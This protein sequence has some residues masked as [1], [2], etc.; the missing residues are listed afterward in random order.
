MNDLRQ[1]NDGL[2]NI[3]GS[4]ETV[5]AA[6]RTQARHLTAETASSMDFGRVKSGFAI[7]LHMH[8]PLIPAGGVDLK[9]AEIVSNLDYMRN[10]QNVGDNHNS[11]VFHW[12]YKRMGAPG[13][14]RQ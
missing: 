6:I 3:C 5:V 1:N 10:H 8:Q 14:E 2:P 7:A 13:A 9:T 12:C 11:P 4:E